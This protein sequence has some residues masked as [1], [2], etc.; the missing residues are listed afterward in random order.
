MAHL[1]QHP[2]LLALAVVAMTNIGF[3]VLP[4]RVLDAEKMALIIGMVVSVTVAF[5]FS[6]FSNLVRMKRIRYKYVMS[7]VVGIAVG[8]VVFFLLRDSSFLSMEWINSGGKL[9][10]IALNVIAALVLFF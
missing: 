7:G 2:R 3:Y 6:A 10:L 9:V 1:P 4:V 8:A 5:V